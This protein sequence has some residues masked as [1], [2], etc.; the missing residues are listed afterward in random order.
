MKEGNIIHEISQIHFSAISLAKIQTSDK[1][2]GK[3]IEKPT[4]SHIAG[5]TIIGISPAEGNL[6][7]LT[8]ISKTYFV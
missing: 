2:C 4:V 5:G 6:T 7:I 8:K 1:F 3:P